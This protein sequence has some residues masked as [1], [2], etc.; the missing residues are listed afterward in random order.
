MSLRDGTRKMSKSDPSSKSRIDL[1]DGPD[2]IAKKVRKA[3]TDSVEGSFRSA[4]GPESDRPEVRNLVGMI[5][6]LRTAQK[7]GGGSGIGGE[8]TDTDVCDDLD[9]RNATA[10]DLKADRVTA[11]EMKLKINIFL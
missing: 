9:S 7:V 5:A 4:V 6:A 3:K 8:W 2:A 11:A 10:K 1:T